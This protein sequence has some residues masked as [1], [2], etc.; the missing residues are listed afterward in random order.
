M[1][2]LAGEVVAGRFFDG[3]PGLQ[4]MARAAFHR[5][6]EGLPEDL[7]WWVNAADPASPCG[8]AAID[9]GLALPRRVPSNHLVFHGRRLVLTSERRGGRLTI[10]VGPD[11]P[12]LGDYLGVL[13]AQLGRSVQ[14]RSAITVDEINGQPAGT[15]P[16]RPGLQDAFQVSRTPTALK[17]SR[18]Y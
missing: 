10:A 12:R 8:L 6:E 1:L 17:L 7:V 15:S 9:L 5:L 4:F 2:E 16:Y 13:R 3:I 11:H 18:R 14:P